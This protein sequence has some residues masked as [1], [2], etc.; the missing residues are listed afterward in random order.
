MQKQVQRFISVGIDHGTCNS[1]VA[2]MTPQGP[3]IVKAD[4]G[5]A[6]STILPSVV[7]MGRDGQPVVGAQARRRMLLNQGDGNGYTEYKPRLGSDDRFAFDVAGKTVKA[8]DLGEIIIG[9]M[10]DACTP[11]T[12]RRPLATVITVPAKYDNTR[13]TGTREATMAAL[14]RPGDPP[15]LATC[16]DRCVMIAEPIAAAM[17]YGF[18]T[19]DEDARWIVFDIGAGTLDVSLVAVEDGMMEVPR[20]GHAGDPDLGGRVLDRALLE[21]ALGPKTSD[22][23]KGQLFRRLCADYRP[24]RSQY[25]LEDF[26]AES[27]PG[28][29]ARL[30]L[31]VEEAKIRLSTEREAV[32]LL[33]DPLCNDEAGRPVDV[34][35]PVTREI[36]EK[37]ITPHVTRAANCCLSLLHNN[38]LSAADIDRIIMVGGPSKTPYIQSE[39]QRRLRI[40]LEASIDPMTAVACGAAILA[41][42]E[43]MPEPVL[44]VLQ[45]E[46][47]DARPPAGV[48]VDLSYQPS[49]QSPVCDVSGI[50]KSDDVD[51]FTGFSITVERTDGGW[52]SP[53]IAVEDDGWF[54]S[55]LMLISS[56][57]PVQSQFRTSVR[58]P[59]GDLVAELEEPAIWHPLTDSIGATLPNDIMIH[60]DGNRT[61]ALLEAGALLPERGD[62]IFR[63][64]RAIRS[65]RSDDHCKVE[66]LEAVTNHVGEEDA[67]ADCN[68]TI[69]H[70]LI[71]GDHVEDDL[72]AGDEL[73]VTVTVTK[74]REVS[75][76][77]DILKTDQ[78]FEGSFVS[79]TY[80]PE[81][82]DLRRRMASI[83]RSLDEARDLV[84]AVPS[85]EVSTAIS[86]VDEEQAIE[87]IESN[88]ALAEAGN[89]RAGW[90][91]YKGILRLAGTVNYVSKQQQAT[92]IRRRL[93]DLQGKLKTE[94]RTLF[95]A[96]RGA[97]DAASPDELDAVEEQVG[98]LVVQ[99]VCQE[100]GELAGLLN[101][102][103]HAAQHAVEEYAT[104]LNANVALYKEAQGH[105]DELFARGGEAEVR[106]MR[107]IGDMARRGMLTEADQAKT[108][109]YIQRL[110]GIPE[111]ESMHTSYVNCPQC[112]G[113]GGGTT[114][115][116]GG[117]G[118][119]L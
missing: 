88:L 73:N 87:S 107:I 67:H 101:S 4:P 57:R 110:R 17:A 106:D 86:R 63:L 109:E 119:D 77:V 16:S 79:E 18:S 2:I 102:F 78:E 95:D 70:I 108:S 31:A 97:V 113:G 83:K 39:L 40:E 41:A 1:C 99:V 7:F 100:M 58:D 62:A 12:G 53:P 114:T 21:F 28:A 75:V 49:S 30:M 23:A 6:G 38:R 81:L 48:A 68:L 33:P 51:D 50:L 76:L 84:Q 92:R 115:S 19:D 85:Q 105:L 90:L 10:L 14:Q 34:E 82:K 29:W 11:H 15:E 111:M 103:V 52:Q 26:S 37:L 35:I 46:W 32:I 9:T 72:E 22:A 61:H 42:R 80:H 24:L 91:A 118:I 65:G 5:D 54:E 96:I 13:Y 55:E 71:A 36:Y 104:V 94:D 44:A 20:K 69:G 66:I 45:Q 116:G 89:K 117:P 8:E 47:N 60:I 25:K 93:D 43:P 59:R 27:Q 56:E 74:S 98:D 112:Q 64:T 3:Q